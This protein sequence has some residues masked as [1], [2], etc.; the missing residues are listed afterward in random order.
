MT[1]TLARPM[2]H[3]SHSTDPY[4]E[5]IRCLGEVRRRDVAIE[6]DMN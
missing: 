2:G 6:D 1:K 4:S 5:A 3:L